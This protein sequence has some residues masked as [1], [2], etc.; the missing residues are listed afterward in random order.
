ELPAVRLRKLLTRMLHHC[1]ERNQL[2]DG[3]HGI[4]RVGDVVPESASASCRESA[5]L[6]RVPDW[7]P[8]ED[9]PKGLFGHGDLSRGRCGH[10][11][12][13]LAMQQIQTRLALD[14]VPGQEQARAIEG[15]GVQQAERAGWPGLEP[16]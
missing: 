4:L 13:T 14:G 2:E 15:A 8:V 3:A 11:L 6:M 9:A 7:G 1:F 12:R 5:C 10:Q 16:P